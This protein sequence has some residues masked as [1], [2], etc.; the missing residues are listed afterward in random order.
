MKNTTLF[1]QKNKIK[2][3]AFFLLFLGTICFAQTNNATT[4]TTTTTTEV[5]Y[6]NP[7][8]IIIGIV[9]LLIMIILMTRGKNKGNLQ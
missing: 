7:L 2:I 4:T 3:I 5:W 1:I 9:V 6:T 8:Y